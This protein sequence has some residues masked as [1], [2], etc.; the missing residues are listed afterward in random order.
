MTQGPISWLSK[1]K[2]TVALST[3]EAE[4]VAIIT[5]TQEAVYT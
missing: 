1:K 2:S 4:Y 5:A 3:L